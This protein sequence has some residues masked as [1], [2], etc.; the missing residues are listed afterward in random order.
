MPL[1]KCHLNRMDLYC[2]VHPRCKLC[3]HTTS[4]QPC[5]KSDTRPLLLCRK[6]AYQN[7]CSRVNDARR[8]GD[9]AEIVQTGSIAYMSPDVEEV[10]LDQKSEL[11]S[12][13]IEG[14]NPYKPNLPCT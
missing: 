11:I 14:E 6:H 7:I 12:S 10:V 4:F 3:G 8:P 9:A 2:E 1:L 5:E 13:N